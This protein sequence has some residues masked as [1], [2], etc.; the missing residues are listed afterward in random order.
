MLT[1]RAPPPLLPQ[2]FSL[3]ITTVP[4]CVIRAET[5]G[6]KYEQ[7]LWSGAGKMELDEE[8]ARQVS[9][10]LSVSCPRCQSLSSTSSHVLTDH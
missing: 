9:F 2:L 5:E 1:S 6:I 7:S 3:I 10:P 8:A 4:A